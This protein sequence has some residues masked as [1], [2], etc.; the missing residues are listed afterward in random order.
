[1][2]P[3]LQNSN[4]HPNTRS[5]GTA[6]KIMTNTRI[7]RRLAMRDEAAFDTRIDKVLANPSGF[8]D[9][10]GQRTKL[11]PSKLAKLKSDL[12]DAYGHAA[13]FASNGPLPNHKKGRGSPPDNAK[14]IFIDDIVHAIEGVGLKPGLRYNEPVS[15]PVRIYKELSFLL[16]PGG[17][18]PRRLFERWQRNRIRRG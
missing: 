8:P 7:E 14:L 10:K 1:M 15:L 17:A 5:S 16:W 6:D 18:D 12:A 3:H 2:Q 4:A 11:S 13:V 9:G